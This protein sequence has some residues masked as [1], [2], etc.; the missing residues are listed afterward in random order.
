MEGDTLFIPGEPATK[1]LGAK[2]KKYDTNDMK[3]TENAGRDWEE[4]WALRNKKS[5]N[6]S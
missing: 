3:T 6:P 5:G 2:L 4:N 1:S